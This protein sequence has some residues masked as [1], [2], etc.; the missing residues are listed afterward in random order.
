MKI[1]LLFFVI[2]LSVLG[3]D[4]SKQINF[5]TL[6]QLDGPTLAPNHVNQ[7]APWSF[8]WKSALV[9]EGLVGVGSSINPGLYGPTELCF[10]ELAIGLVQDLSNGKIEEENLALRMNRYYEHKAIFDLMDHSGPDR[11]KALALQYTLNQE[12]LPIVRKIAFFAQHYP[13][14]TRAIAIRQRL[15]LL[16]HLIGVAETELDILYR[17]LI[18]YRP[19]LDDS[20]LPGVTEFWD[21]L[22]NGTLSGI[23]DFF[24]DEQGVTSL[25]ISE[26]LEKLFFYKG[27]S[28]FENIDNEIDQ[29][30]FPDYFV[31]DLVHHAMY[32]LFTDDS[33]PALSG[34]ELE[35][36]SEL[37]YVSK[38]HFSETSASNGASFIKQNNSLLFQAK[39]RLTVDHLSFPDFT[40]LPKDPRNEIL[41]YVPSLVVDIS[42]KTKQFSQRQDFVRFLT[43]DLLILNASARSSWV[44]LEASKSVMMLDAVPPDIISHYRISHPSCLSFFRVLN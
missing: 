6:F 37:A 24:Q 14:T 33:L 5:S 11:K 28:N 10:A 25:V 8:F 2:S 22:E 4:K 16:G 30:I 21:E 20:E 1:V 12:L 18:Q 42:D 26:V 43:M 19:N 13:E 23:N 32:W 7:G 27:N 39:D 36:F 35:F 41:G 9:G 17:E 38:G 29:L 15:T 34:P 44:E 31:N 3:Q 40:R